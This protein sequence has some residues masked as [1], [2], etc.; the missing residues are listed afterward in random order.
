VHISQLAHERVENVSDVVSEGDQIKVKVISVDQD[1]GRLSLSLKDTL[2]GPWDG[3]SNEF[4]QGD[5]VEGE[6]KRIANFGAFVEIKPGV[7]GLVHISQISKEH[8][9]N[10]QEVVKEGQKVKVKILDIDEEAKRI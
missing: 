2:P 8:I 3:I 5:I 4:K 6:V 1:K 10:P 9:G 7:E